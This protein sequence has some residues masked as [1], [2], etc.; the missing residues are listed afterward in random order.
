MDSSPS[1]MR[2]SQP[3][4]PAVYRTA[5]RRAE[6]TVFRR[7]DGAQRARKI[8]MLQP[9]LILLQPARPSRRRRFGGACAAGQVSSASY[10][11]RNPD[12]T[13]N[14]SGRST[15]GQPGSFR[16]GAGKDPGCARQRRTWPAPGLAAG[17]AL[18]SEDAFARWQ[19]KLR[20][21]IFSALS[22][23]SFSG[24]DI[25]LGQLSIP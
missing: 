23:A 25:G 9:L 7:P 4:G 12:C 2:F 21:R 22:S 11:V 5:S 15:R 14:S 10:S 8:R 6:Q 19:V 3:Y 1:T 24:L 18:I 20:L 17:L 13:G 16:H